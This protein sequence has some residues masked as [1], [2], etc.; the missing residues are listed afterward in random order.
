METIDI[1]GEKIPLSVLSQ[2]EIDYLATFSKN[3]PDVHWIWS[4]MDRVWNDLKLDN[5]KPLSDQRIADYYGHPIWIVNG[6]FTKFDKVSKGH[7]LAIAKFLEKQGVVNIAD[8]GGGFGEMAI[9]LSE[10]LPNA[11]ISIIEPYP[12]KLGIYRLENFTRVR[13]VQEITN[14]S[15]DAVIAQDVLEH[16]EDPVL[17]A[18]QLT[19]TVKKSG[20]IVFAN[21]FYPYINCHLPSTFHLRHT[22][23]FV[24]KNLGLKYLGVIKGAYH[25]QVY[26]KVAEPNLD[27]VRAA[28]NI[29]RKVGGMVNLPLSTLISKVKRRIFVR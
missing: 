16:V 17:L 14:N 29:S 8:Y 12:S 18:F 23:S 11:D 10:V 27:R 28:E 21:C 22:F 6:L 26:R 19:E 1:W 7:R 3:I 5:T 4:E 13:Q 9:T 2:Y 24:S 20:I 25:A 15:Y